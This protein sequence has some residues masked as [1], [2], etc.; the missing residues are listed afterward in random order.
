MNPD[1]YVNEIRSIEKEEKRLRAVQKKLREQKKKAQGY[2]YTHMESSGVEKYNNITKKS[3][4]PREKKV[5]K[6]AKDKKRDAIEL[7]RL[8]GIPDPEKFWSDFKNTQTTT[9][10]NI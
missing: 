5:R 9:Q 4:T 10:G 6:K 3:I 8:T 7:F 2:L 1:V